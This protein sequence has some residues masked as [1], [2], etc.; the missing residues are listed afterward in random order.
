MISG[1]LAGKL[2]CWAMGAMVGVGVLI[3]RIATDPEQSF[4]WAIGRRSYRH[5]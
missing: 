1:I 2:M 5:R 3:Y 4:L